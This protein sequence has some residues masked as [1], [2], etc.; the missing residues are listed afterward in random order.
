MVLNGAVYAVQFE[1]TV[2]LRQILPSKNKSDVEIYRELC[3]I[4]GN[5][6]SIQMIYGDGANTLPYEFQQLISFVR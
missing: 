5:C 4:Y 3:S 2:H 6:M 1:K